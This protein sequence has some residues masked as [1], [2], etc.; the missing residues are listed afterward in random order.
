MA[1]LAAAGVPM[2]QND[3]TGC[4]VATQTLARAHQLGVFYRDAP[5]LA[6]AL[7]STHRME[8]L[9]DSVW[10]QRDLFTYE[11]HADDFVAFLRDTVHHL[12]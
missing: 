1:T 7:R 9:R 12:R 10:R 8:Q 2:I 6:A 11:A 5:G 3:N 4:V